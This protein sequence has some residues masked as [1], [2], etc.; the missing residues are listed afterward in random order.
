LIGALAR[1]EEYVIVGGIAATQ[2]GATRTTV[3]LD[4]RPRWTRENLDRVARVLMEFEARIAI[5]PTESVP[6]PLIDGVLISRT[7]IGTWQTTAGGL[8]VLSG[9]PKTATET[10]GYEQLIGDAVTVILAG[11]A[12]HVVALAALIR[13]KQI[14]NR[15]KDHEALPELEA[16]AGRQLADL[17]HGDPSAGQIVE[18][19]Q[20]RPCRLSDLGRDSPELG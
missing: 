20:P 11:V 5:T 4:T 3:D 12:V 19:R 8:D 14:A 17:G 13:S 16:I 7:E 6:V 1:W 18:N 10:I 9:I 15:P 2:H